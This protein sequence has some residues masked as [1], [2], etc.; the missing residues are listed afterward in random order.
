MSMPH[1]GWP[2][3]AWRLRRPTPTV[4]PSGAGTVV[5]RTALTRQIARI[6]D[7]WNDLLYEKKRDAKI[8][9]AP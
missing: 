3:A 9:G 2:I 7:A 4:M 5:G 8:G 6:D 1:S